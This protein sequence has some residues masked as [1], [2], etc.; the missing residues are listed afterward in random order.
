[1]VNDYERD[2]GIWYKISADTVKIR[3]STSDKDSPWTHAKFG[4]NLI[5][6]GDIEFTYGNNALSKLY[7]R[8]GGISYGDRSAYQLSFS[9]KIPDTNTKIHI[10]TYPI[11]EGLKISSDG[12]IMGEIDSYTSYPFRIKITDSNGISDIKTVNMTTEIKKHIKNTQ[13]IEIFPSLVVD[14]IFIK[15]NTENI[16]K[17][18]VNIYNQNGI[19]FK[20]KP[21]ESNKLTQ[22]LLEDLAR[23]KYYLRAILKGEEHTST[24]IK[25]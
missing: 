24:F 17:I 11:P 22:I 18:D 6:N 7:P 10:K 4:C 19:L 12:I 1:M 25:L 15:I 20:T 3:W 23:G 21:I 9:D 16:L 14:K 13:L 5:K 8:I 2:E